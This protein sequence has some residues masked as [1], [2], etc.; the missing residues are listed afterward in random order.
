[1]RVYFTFFT[2]VLIFSIIEVKGQSEPIK[3]QWVKDDSVFIEN[4][5]QSYKKNPANL[6]HLLSYKG[7]K[8]EKLGFDYYLVTGSNGKG[9]VSIFYEFVYR[10]N[11][12]VS[13]KLDPQMPL[14]KRLT[15]RYL[16][17]YSSL[18]KIN[19]YQ[20]AEPLYYG[21]DEMIRPLDDFKATIYDDRILF[22]MTPYSGILYGD[23]GGIGSTMLD[24]RFNYLRIEN[25]ITPEICEFLLYSKNPATRLSAIEY[26]LQNPQLFIKNKERIESRINL[27]FNEL[28]EV[29]TMSA[30]L[31]FEKNAKDLVNSFVKKH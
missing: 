18:F 15:E 9:Y 10:K 24:N 30:D 31:E 25:K 14:D 22:F 12:F 29:R 2:I 16:K 3:N 5:A 27:I 7:E 26:Y 11:E 20:I 6:E 13:Y 17:F 8:G 19:K 4:L 23:Y 1:M 28:P 21:Y